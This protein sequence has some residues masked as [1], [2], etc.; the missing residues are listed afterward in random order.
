MGKN[1]SNFSKQ[2]RTPETQT[3]KHSIIENNLVNEQPEIT[4]NVEIQNE[5][6]I[7]TGKVSGCDKLNVRKESNKEAEVLCIIDNNT[8]VHI[9]TNATDSE[10]EFYKVTTPSEIEGYCMK[11]FITIQMDEG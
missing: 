3:H 2:F 5:K 1:Y 7:I 8:I 4:T 9:D 10:N 6:T 11:K